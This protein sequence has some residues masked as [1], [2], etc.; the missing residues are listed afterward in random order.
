MGFS[1]EKLS[2]YFNILIII[3][4]LVIAGAVFYKLST[5]KPEKTNV[6][7]MHKALTWPE[8]ELIINGDLYIL[9][10]FKTVQSAENGVY[11]ETRY[12]LR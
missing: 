1:E 7:I 9:K 11:Y 12:Q 3:G 6:I 4:L 5:K 2:F 10:D 8:Q